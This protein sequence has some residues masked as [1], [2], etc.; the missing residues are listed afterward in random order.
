MLLLGDD[1]AL[2]VSGL[3]GGTAEAMPVPVAA[4]Y[5]AGTDEMRLVRDTV[6]GTGADNRPRL[7]G[8]AAD[9][10]GHT[11]ALVDGFRTGYDLI[12][13]HRAELLGPGGAVQRFAGDELR[14]VARSTRVYQTLLD[15]STHPGVLRDGL[16]RDRLFDVLWAGSA[17]DRVRLRLVRHESAQLWQ[18]DVPI[19]TLRPDRRELRSGSGEQIPDVLARTPLEQVGDKLRQLGAVDRQDQE[20]VIRA[21]LATRLAHRAHEAGEPE[22]HPYPASAP[23]ADR[24]LAAA[25]GIADHIVARGFDD[26]D[27]I[28]WLG[29]EPLDERYWDVMPLGA[30]LATGYTGVAVFLAQLAAVTADARYA[31]VALR[32]LRPLPALIEQLT[33]DPEAARIVGV[34]GFSGFGGI[35]YAL[36][37]VAG[38]LGDHEVAQ[39]V[40]PVVG[41]ADATLDA[42]DDDSVYSGVAG[43]LAAMLAVHAMTGLDPARATAGRAAQRLL[44]PATPRRDGGPGFAFGTAGAGWALLRYAQVAGDAQAGQ[45]GRDHLLAATTVAGGH[46]WCRG[47][48]GAVLALLDTRLDTTGDTRALVESTVAGVGRTGPLANHSLCHGDFGRLELLGAAD[49]PAQLARAGMTLSALDEAGPQCGTPGRVTDPGLLHGLA[50]I[51]HGLLRLAHPD[52]IPAALLLHPAHPHHGGTDE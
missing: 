4:W 5:A 17:G 33:A 7:D 15:E 19:F 3:G 13:G 36:A 48:P 51:G 39:L 38:F 35:A 9:P 29:L 21:A 20:W 16:D 23:D 32:A 24:L 34:G 12:A 43:C 6:H 28:N 46:S 22:P 40:A 37:Q 27:R 30:G 18:G 44:E 50:G 42:A 41:L 10:A 49:R 1:A 52:R 25:R 45:R 47:R 8:V 31:A 11:E 26:G 14:L 2:D